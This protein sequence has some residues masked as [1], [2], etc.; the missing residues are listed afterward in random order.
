M[1]ENVGQGLA[2]WFVKGSNWL[3]I[4]ATPVA[5]ASFADTEFQEKPR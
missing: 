4:D 3:H 1:P 5:P 2:K